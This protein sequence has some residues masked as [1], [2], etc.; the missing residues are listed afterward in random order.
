[1]T[2]SLH[3]LVDRVRAAA[4][5][6]TPLRL[7]GG[8]TRRGHGRPCGGLPLDLRDHHGIVS[9]EPT[10]LVVT[11][12]AGTALADLEAA[13]RAR[14]QALAFEPPRPAVGGTVGGMLATGLAGPARPKAGSVRD[15]VLGL[16]LIDG[17]GRVLR[18]GGTV[19]K[20]VAGY[21]ISR[22][23]VGAFGTL[24]VITEVSLRVLARPVEQATLA[25]DLPL[26]TALDH[27][28]RWAAQPLPI[29]A[30]GWHRGQLTVRLAGAHAAVATAARTLGGAVLPAP[31]GEAYWGGLRDRRHPF[32]HPGSAAAEARLWRLSLPRTAPMP[33]LDSHADWLVEWHGAQRWLWSTATAATVHAAAQAV[34]GHAACLHGATLPPDAEA[35]TRPAPALMAI[36]QRLKDTFDPLR[37]LN[38]GRLYADL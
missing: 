8:D 18:F 26:P 9:H 22:A 14:G 6:R 3:R 28:H 23:M 25:F 34:G 17:Q 15:H 33:A 32:F 37:L 30:S 29:D 19:M 2:A 4:A 38:R 13:L 1:M 27:L 35:F 24:G 5:D 31:L 20:N 21:D 11:V 7:V 36:Q 12:K 16:Q 10:E